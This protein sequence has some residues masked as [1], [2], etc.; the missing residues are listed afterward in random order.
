MKYILPLLMVILF[1]GILIGANVYLAR[2]FDFFFT[3]DSLRALYFVFG[4]TTL[5]MFFGGFSTANAV[6]II[7]HITN[8]LAFTLLG[9]F[10]YLLLSTL[11]VDL[12]GLLINI[13]PHM[14]GVI[15]FGLAITISVY[16]IINARYT[17]ITSETI[18]ITGLQKEIRALHLTDTHSAG[19]CGFLYRR[20]T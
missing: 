20:S 9:F 6:G 18:P 4:V 11:L 1:F 3:L 8:L 17:Q 14:K 15:S 19:R 12:T 16:G 2:R 7:G 5:F 10:L 13:S